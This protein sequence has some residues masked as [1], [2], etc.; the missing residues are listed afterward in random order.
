MKMTMDDVVSVAVK[1]RIW[2]DAP[3]AVKAFV[4]AN[5]RPI[6][7]DDVSAAV[8]AG[9]WCEH[10]RSPPPEA[11]GHRRPAIGV[12]MLLQEHRRENDGNERSDERDG[13]EIRNRNSGASAAKVQNVPT[14]LKTPRS[15]WSDGR[16][17]RNAPRNCPRQA[18][19]IRI[20]ISANSARKNATCPSG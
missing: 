13:R 8:I 14:M 18:N 3:P 11:E 6:V 19:T 5:N 4:N 9:I 17:V 2:I 10:Q 7:I 16:L 15:R 20:G 1:R 12:D